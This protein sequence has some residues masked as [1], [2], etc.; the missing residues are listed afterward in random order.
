[1]SQLAWWSHLA[2]LAAAAGSLTSSRQPRS[3]RCALSCLMMKLTAFAISTRP[4]SAQRICHQNWTAGLTICSSPRRAKRCL[5]TV[6]PWVKR[7]RPSHPRKASCPAGKMICPAYWPNQASLSEVHPISNITCQCSTRSPIHC[8]TICQKR[9][10]C[11]LMMRL[12]Y[13]RPCA[14]S[15]SRQSKSPRNSPACRPATPAP[16]LTATS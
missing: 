15:T 5:A 10:C 11:W 3:C 1:M 4:R 8:W 2:N 6:A 7:L 16:S 13:W 9:V 12:N 14:S